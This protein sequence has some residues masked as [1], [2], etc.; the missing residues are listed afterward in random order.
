[1]KFLAK[2]KRF[3]LLPQM[4]L[5]IS[6]IVFSSMF[7]GSLIFSL[8][9]KDVLIKNIDKHAMSI[10]KMTAA[11]PRIIQAFDDKNPSK[12]MVLRQMLG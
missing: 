5:L 11:D 12:V 6:I 7:L 2:F 4:V 1:M 9:L 3:G 8:I 10:A